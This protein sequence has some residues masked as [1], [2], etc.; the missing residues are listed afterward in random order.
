MATFTRSTP[1]PVPA[2]ELAAWHERP[3]ALQRLLP[4]WLDVHV[5][6]SDGGVQDGDVTVL[7]VPIGPLRLMWRARHHDYVAGR[8]FCD[9]QERGPFAHWTHTHRFEPNG[10]GSV[11][12]DSVEY[13]LPLGAVGEAVAGS[14]V[15]HML[16]RMFRWRHARTRHDLLRHVAWSRGRPLTVA[17][18]GASGFVGA[19][20]S[21]FLST[22]G[23]RVLPIVR[24]AAQGPHEI[25][26]DPGTG[27]IEADKLSG[28][29]A[30]IHLAGAG[31]ADHRWTPSYRHAIRHSRV[32]G[33]GLIAR[34]LAALPA[35]KRPAVLLS[36][37]ALG[38]Y[39][40][41]GDEVLD[42]TA[43][44][45]TGF[46]ASVVRDWE[47]A[48][49]P[50]RAAG[51]RVV[52]PRIGLV[53][54]ARGGALAAMLPLF[55]AGLGGPLGD[56]R[57][58]MSWIHLDDLLAL[59]LWALV[60]DRVVGVVNAVA[61]EPVLNRDFTRILARV[62]HRPALLPVPAFALRA[63]LGS[64]KAQEML[65]ASTRVAPVVAQTLGFPFLFA[66]LDRALAYEFGAAGP[67]ELPAR[68]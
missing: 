59:L 47:A 64:Q 54:G 36:A 38:F 27:T 32:A 40:D 51:V 42:E 45:G 9:T 20:L 52:H 16:E 15:N 60:D 10:E 50:A 30:V 57:M 49:E 55:R 61:P 1:M 23:H 7:A 63:A 62:L 19:A 65:L 8:Q 41:R 26:W 33:T 67:D 21:A 5:L 37:S 39:G 11:L 68:P 12:I 3:G 43:P 24:R 46:L 35:G 22:G 25:S 2:I 44:S 58:W 28:V 4:P 29:D 14:A 48:A 66:T 17:I 13:T 34:T 53:L 18:T 56:G 31:V 6:S